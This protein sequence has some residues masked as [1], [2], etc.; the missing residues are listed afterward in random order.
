MWTAERYDDAAHASMRAPH[1]AKASA[2][3]IVNSA[4][5]VGG[6][7]SVFKFNPIDRSWRDARTVTLTRA[8]RS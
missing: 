3:D 6:V 1:V 2:V 4:F 5:D 7:R 8:N